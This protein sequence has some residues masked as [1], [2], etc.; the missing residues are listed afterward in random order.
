MITRKPLEENQ[1]VDPNDPTTFKVKSRWCLQ[2]HL[3]PD[4]DQKLLDGML[5]SPTL[6]QIGR[7]LLMQVI[8]SYQWDLQ[9]GDIKGAFLESGP[10]PSKYRPLY[11][12]QPRG[13]IPGVPPEAVLEVAG[14]VYGQNDAPCAWCRTFND[15]AIQSGWVR[16]KFDSC[17]YS[18]VTIS[19]VAVDSWG[20]MLMI[21]Q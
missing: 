10:L 18:C 19:L 12:S 15:E 20:C 5:K 1:H 7:M 2:G 13:G 11:A 17:L 3:D 14:N 8:S 4:L 16:S 21:Q 6:S 9:L